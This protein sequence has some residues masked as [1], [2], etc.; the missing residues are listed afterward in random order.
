MC[1]RTTTSQKVCLVLEAMAAGVPVVQPDHGA[2]GE[3]IEST[4]GGVLFTPGNLRSL[5]DSIQRLKDDP[6]LRSQLA[7]AGR[8]KV[9][10][11]HSIKRA[12][13]DMHKILNAAR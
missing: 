4:G 3:L 7:K 10:A 1:R 8:E 6:V 5:C 9:L 2:F 12:S 11:N 13:I